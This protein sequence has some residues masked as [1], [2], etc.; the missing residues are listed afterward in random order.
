MKLRKNL[1]QLTKKQINKFAEGLS[2]QEAEQLYYDWYLWA[3][4]DQLPPN[5]QA[6]SAPFKPLNWRNWILLG[7][8]GAGKTRAG[9]EWIRAM[10]LGIAPF[11][12]K[13]AWRI[14]LIGETFN[15]V[16]EV[17]LEGDSGLLH[18]H[19]EHQRPTYIASRKRLE[20]PNGAVAQL[21]SAEEPESLRGP[22]FH[23]AWCDEF[24][25]WQ[26]DTEVWDM[27]QFGMRLGDNPQIVLTTTPRNKKQLKDMLAMEGSFV[28]K[29]ST[30]ANKQN[31]AAAF[32]SNID[33]NYAGTNLGR[34]ELYGEIIEDRQGALW[35]S[36]VIESLRR[37]QKDY[38][39]TEFKRIILAIDPPATSHKKSNACGMIVAAMDENRHVYII[40]DVTMQTAAPI[41]WA[42]KA[43]EIYHQFN[44]DR[45]VAEVNQGG[46]MV[47]TILRTIDSQ[48]S[49]SAVFAKKDKK[50]RAEPV[51]A[52][53]EQGKVHHLGMFEAL[54]DE[55]C[56]FDHLIGSSK[57]SPDRVDAL[58]WAVS[59]LHLNGGT[60][61]PRI[62]DL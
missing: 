44:I 62:R 15:D 26:Y 58:V 22:Q 43:V 51:A 45:I 18:I 8:R 53:Y 50:S 21:F 32:I 14:A 61:V 28:S 24:A 16:C 7:G 23:A 5:L 40:A 37:R 48:I 19:P 55:M 4:D 9:A 46:E 49:Y 3:R 1:R 35:Q 25:K 38:D 36:E 60:N 30:F 39:L 29:A 59:H 41:V 33:Q 27:L 13:P 56:Q 10:A 47:E 42:K 12:S 11:A 17:M 52:L 6:Q 31:L 57:L 34:Q 20:W 54:E 2:E